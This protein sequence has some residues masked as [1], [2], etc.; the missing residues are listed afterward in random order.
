MSRGQILA[1][2]REPKGAV[3]GSRLS[4]STLSSQ[5]AIKEGAN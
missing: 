4:Q 3:N 5:H 2:S 1:L